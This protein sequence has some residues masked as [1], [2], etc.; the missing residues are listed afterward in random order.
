MNEASVELL[1]SIGLS[2]ERSRDLLSSS[3]DVGIHLLGVIKDVCTVSF[4]LK[5]INLLHILC[6]RLRK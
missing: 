5:N 1:K 4:M 6:F 2:E 3:K